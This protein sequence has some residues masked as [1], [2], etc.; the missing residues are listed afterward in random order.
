MIR[1]ADTPA[2]IGMTP[3][4]IWVEHSKRLPAIFGEIVACGPGAELQG[5]RVGM[6]VLFVRYAGEITD[7]YEDGS[8]YAIFSIND[9][10]AEIPK[11]A[12]RYTDEEVARFNLRPNFAGVP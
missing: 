3:S 11:E 9:V 6:F 10:L 7:E 8:A 4:G 2:G 5:Y 12:L 1:F